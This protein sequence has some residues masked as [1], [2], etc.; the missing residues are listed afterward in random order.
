M[1][2]GIRVNL[3]SNDPQARGLALEQ[4]EIPEGASRFAIP[5][6]TGAGGLFD[7]G[8][9]EFQ[10]GALYVVL[11]RTHQMWVEFFGD[12]IDWQSRVAQ[13][14]VNPRAGKDFNAYYDRTGLKFFYAPDKT[15][16]QPIYTCE[17]ADVSAHECG[18][19]ILDARHSDYWDSLL[20]ET[21][22]FHEA[23]GDVSA[24]LLAL[25]DPAVRAAMLEETGGDL[26]KSNAVT[27]LAEQL[28]RGLASAG[29]ADA[30]VSPDALRDFVNQFKYQDPDTLPGRA[31][32]AQ[33]SSESHN[34]ARVF[35][36][37]FYD[38]LVGVYNQLR[39]EDGSLTDDTALAQA[40]VSAGHILGEGLDLAPRGDAPFKTVA[41]SMFKSN[42]LLFAG[43]HFDALESAFVG[44]NII[45]ASDADRIRS[46]NGRG[47]TQ[48]SSGGE[49][50]H[51]ALP[52]R[53]GTAGVRVGKEFPAE[54]AASLGLSAREFHLVGELDRSDAS[55]VLDFRKERALELL[56]DRFGVARGVTLSLQDS[57][58]VLLDWSGKLVASHAQI[59]DV[60]HEDRIQD[61]IEKL[62]A[63]KRVYVG[64]EGKAIDPNELIERHQPYYVETDAE[65][66]RR[67]RRGFVACG[68]R[69]GNV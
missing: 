26:A 3:F 59:A 69:K 16:G 41:L 67:L 42:A 27:R 13:L 32:A 1:G 25:G 65:G 68:A 39:A 19:A 40:R 60:A 4:V 66:K 57:V 11:N 34:F 35:T 56:D 45:A 54:V 22:A 51:K 29:Y 18:H 15:T 17:S 12:P 47:H 24:L 14:P 8:T 43:K 36:G 20:A 23:F 2:S 64:E 58:S 7:P 63:R 49:T 62:V 52:A 48:T 9:P 33:L 38:F 31:P 53:L 44:R 6:W 50:L 10:A 55:R 37:A 21:G 28:A 61:H 5:G 30:V 46:T